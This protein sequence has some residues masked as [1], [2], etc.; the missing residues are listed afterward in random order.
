M[1]K[2]SIAILVLCPAGAVSVTGCG[3]ARG[4]QNTVKQPGRND[5]KIDQATAKETEPETEAEEGMIRKLV[6]KRLVDSKLTLSMCKQTRDADR[7]SAQTQRLSG[8]FH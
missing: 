4:N 5:P 3:S 2:R 1:K 8:Y 6:R 7:S